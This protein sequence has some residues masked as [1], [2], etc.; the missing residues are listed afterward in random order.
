MNLGRLTYVAPLAALVTAAYAGCS[1]ADPS[2]GDTGTVEGQQVK[3]SGTSTPSGSGAATGTAAKKKCGIA[4]RSDIKSLPGTLKTRLCELA[5]RPHAYTPMTAFAEADPPSMLFQHYLI[6]A[7]GFQPNVFTAEIPGINDG[8]KPTAT[9]PNG[10]M[11]AIGAVR[12][13]L[14]PKP[15]KPTDPN[16]VHAAIDVFTDV[17]GLF[18]INN[19]SGWYEGWM[20]TDLKVPAIDP[21]CTTTGMTPHFGLISQA[22]ADALAA[23]G[24]GNNVPGNFFTADG[25]PPKFP[26]ATDV[27]PTQMTNLVNFPVSLGTF[28]ALQQGEIHA[29]WEF[30]PGT[31]WAFPTFELPASGGIPGTYDAGLYGSISSLI[32]GSGPA[33]IKNSPLLFGDNPN[34]PRDP[35][36]SEIAMVSDIDRPE[37]GNPAHLEKRNR[38]LPSGLV[39]E[40]HLDVFMR[41]ASFEPGVGMPQRLFD[42][43]AKEVAKVD[44]NGDGVISF[45]EAEIEGTSD[46]GQPNTRLYVPATQFNRYAMTRELNDGLLAPRFAPSQRGYVMAGNLTTVS[47]AVPASVPRDADDR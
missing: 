3:G 29:Y 15:G 37:A 24:A 25:G 16:D 35:D 31:N 17:S 40:I 7:N 39:K 28:N 8:T 19:E 43:Y 34:D 30:N 26:S 5:A 38:F 36:R 12:V 23:M 32:P 20:I 21:A 4:G 9:G 2:S 33:G 10:N 41:V 46:G 42:A 47:P 45:E 1:S 14:E 44:K 22:D 18:V 6:D 27:F 11:P 13:V